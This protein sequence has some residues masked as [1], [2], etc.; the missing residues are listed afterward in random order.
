MNTSHPSV[1]LVVLACGAAFSA[2]APMPAPGPAGL[3]AAMTQLFGD[4]TAFS[5]RA[6]VRLKD[7]ARKDTLSMGMDFAV[8]DGKMR[9]DIDLAQIKSKDMSPETVASLKQ[10]GMDKMVTI[11]RPDRKSTLV[12]YPALRAYAEAPMS[13]QDSEDLARTYKV[14]KTKLGTER[15]DGHPCDQYRV[16]V[17]SEKGDRH[18]ALV[19]YAA[20]VKG[21]PI[22]MQLNQPGQAPRPRLRSAR[23][24]LQTHERREP[25]AGGNDEDDGRNGEV[26]PQARREANGSGCAAQS[27]PLTSVKLS[28]ARLSKLP[29]SSAD[30]LNASAA[31]LLVSMRR[32]LVMAVG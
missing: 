25:D 26:K 4:F 32:L 12:V 13:K 23:G 6:E 1:L 27:Q 16:T 31:F 30:R 3:N 21:F 10:L 7:K 11:V 22:Q 20:D 19:W 5:A 28:Q 8:L 15:V 24:I 29:V 17:T 18:E 2:T 14:E 9:A